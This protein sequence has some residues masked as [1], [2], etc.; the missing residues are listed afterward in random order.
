MT[1]PAGLLWMTA[2]QCSRCANSCRTRPTPQDDAETRS[3]SP[4]GLLSMSMVRDDQDDDG[5]DERLAVV[6]LH[7]LCSG[8]AASRNSFHRRFPRPVLLSGRRKTES[9]GLRG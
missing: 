1:L 5:D 2:W 7:N 9:L 3:S 6:V 4:P 8:G